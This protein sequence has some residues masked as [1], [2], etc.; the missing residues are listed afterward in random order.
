MLM[1][2]FWLESFTPTQRIHTDGDTAILKLATL[3][4]E[5]KFV[6]VGTV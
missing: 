6:I 3:D 1:E 4:K 5:L 2:F